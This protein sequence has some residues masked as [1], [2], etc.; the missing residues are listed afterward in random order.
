ML[1]TFPFKTRISDLAD[2]L[3]KLDHIAVGLAMPSRSLDLAQS[4]Q[5][6][7]PWFS[8]LQTNMDYK[9]QCNKKKCY[10]EGP[11]EI[12]EAVNN[13]NV[14]T[15][16]RFEIRPESMGKFSLKCHSKRL[17]FTIRV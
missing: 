2:K 12:N 9:E 11:N 3:D 10:A 1:D 14:E 16:S 17:Y 7:K 13:G 4:L 8:H 5:I 6:S 15:C